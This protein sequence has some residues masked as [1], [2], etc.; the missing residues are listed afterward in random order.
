[1]TSLAQFITHFGLLTSQVANPSSATGH[2]RPRSLH[3]PGQGRLRGIRSAVDDPCRARGPGQQAMAELVG[4]D[5]L[6]V[7]AQR[8]TQ[9]LCW[10]QPGLKREVWCLLV[11][12]HGDEKRHDTTALLASMAAWPS[13]RGWQAENEI[14]VVD[15]SKQLASRTCRSCVRGCRPPHGRT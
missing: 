8:R 1:M 4:V 15:C 2:R 10:R 12:R 11:V 6:V 3:A 7:D 14:Y 13:A 5:F 9:R